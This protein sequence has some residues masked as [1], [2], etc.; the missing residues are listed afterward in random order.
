MTA[1]RLTAHLL[2]ATFDNGWSMLRGPASP[3]QAWPQGFDLHLNTSPDTDALVQE[4]AGRGLQDARQ[5]RAM[6]ALTVLDRNTP[7]V[8]IRMLG[9]RHRTR[10]AAH[11]LALDAQ[12]RYLR[13]GYQASDGQIQTYVQGLD[14][15]RD[16][17]YGVFNRRLQ[18]IALAH[19][20]LTGQT[21]SSGPSAEFGVSV[22]PQSRGKRL[23]TRLFDRAITHAR[24]HSVDS[25]FIHALT[26]NDAMIRIARHAG[27]HIQTMDGEALAHVQLLPASLETHVE[28]AF[29]NGIGTLDYRL[30]RR[31]QQLWQWR[32]HTVVESVINS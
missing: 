17:I 21:D 14:F 27:A 24:A 22:D 32:G 1:L 7:F 26:Q 20:A 15:R 8:P 11:L 9:P 19:L 23:G 31:A 18:L 2:Q 29:E 28:D 10:I 3:R 6:Q 12:D 30:K 13:F 4:Y 16:K 25:L 5:S